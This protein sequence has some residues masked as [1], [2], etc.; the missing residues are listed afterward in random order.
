[1]KRIR[2]K[3]L[4][5]AAGV[6]ALTAT[7]QSFAQE[8]SVP[9]Q[10]SPCPET[11][12]FAGPEFVPPMKMHKPHFDVNKFEQDLNLTDAQKNRLNKLEKKMLKQ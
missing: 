1:M 12:E 9:Q 7:T 10:P 3:K 11:H 8:I 5:I 2:M 4:L 6:I